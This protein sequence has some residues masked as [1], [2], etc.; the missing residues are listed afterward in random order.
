MSSSSNAATTAAIVDDYTTPP[1]S[2]PPSPRSVNI[3]NPNMWGSNTDFRDPAACHAP[4]KVSAQNP[5]TPD[6]EKR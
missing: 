3:P 2:P 5:P 1:P 6:E 4:L